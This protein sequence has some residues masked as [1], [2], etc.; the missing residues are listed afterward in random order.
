M[1]KSSI[2]VASSILIITILWIASGQFKTEEKQKANEEEINELDK[3]NNF[4]NV[5][6]KNSIAQ[7]INKSVVIQGQTHANRKI[8]I[9]SETSGKIQKVN[10]S[11][12]LKIK[13][14][15]LIFKISEN[16]R[17]SKFEKV[18]IEYESEKKLFEKG[19]SSKLK[20]A[21][22]KSNYD[23]IKDD[24]N[25]TNVLAPFDGIMTAE[26]LEVG[27]FVQPGTTLTTFVELDPILV[28]GF[29][30][31]KELKNIYESK[32]AYVS[33]M[34]NEK[35]KGDITYISSIAEEKTRTFRI[36]ITLSNK[37]YTI[38]DGLTASIEIQGEKIKAHKISPSILSLRDNGE[39]GIKIV[40]ENNIVEFY[41][42]EV[43]SDTNDG[44]WVTGIPNISNIIV[45]GQDYA[46]IGDKVYLDKIN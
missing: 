23:T 19:L 6:I 40:N 46:P 27:E 45:V 12:G 28:V 30:S 29:I 22:V 7:E 42:I 16:D 25:K 38:K 26:H 36:E 41:N 32:E 10:K 4:I 1:K 31:E 34:L 9:K 8:S 18:K 37:N 44:M 11:S 35:I 39:M 13:K 21:T 15:E 2:F 3:N 20:L 24:L 14:D 17:K 33:T 5:R 43:I